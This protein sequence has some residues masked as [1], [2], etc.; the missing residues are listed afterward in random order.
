MLPKPG[1]CCSKAKPGALL[2]ALLQS[3][4]SGDLPEHEGSGTPVLLSRSSFGSAFIPTSVI[5]KIE[6]L[7]HILNR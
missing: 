4:S 2:C 1:C 7:Y 6:Y 3:A 5:S